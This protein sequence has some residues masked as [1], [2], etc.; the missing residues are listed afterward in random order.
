MFYLQSIKGFIS[1]M[2]IRTK[3]QVL[4]VGTSAV[5][6]VLAAMALITSEINNFRQEL[7]A[8]LNATAN[9]VGQNVYPSLI[10]NYA[11]SAGEILSSLSANE[12]ITKA[13]IVSSDRKIFA[14][15]HRDD[16]RQDSPENVLSLD[17][18]YLFTSNSIEVVQ[19]IT[20]DGQV[21]GFVLIASDLKKLNQRLLR[22]YQIAALV[23]VGAVGLAF[24]LAR[25]FQHFISAPI[26]QLSDTMQYVTRTKKYSIRAEKTTNDEVGGLIDG[27]NQMLEEMNK[28][29]AD[30]FKVNK[31]LEKVVS[32]LRIAK[33]AAEK[34]NLA[35]SQF[36]AK[37]SHEIRTPMNGVLGMVDLLLNSGLTNQQNRLAK[38]VRN[39]GVTL[40]EII[41]DILDFAKIE[42]DKIDLEI[43]EFNLVELV[44]SIC[45]LLGQSAYNKGIELG[46]Y[47]DARIPVIVKGDPLRMRQ[48]LINLMGNAV[49]FTSDGQVSLNVHLVE[50]HEGYVQARFEVIDSGVG[51]QEEA[52][53]RI[54]EAFSQANEETSRRFGGTGLGLSIAKQLVG[55]MGGDLAVKSKPNLGATFY[56]TINLPYVTKDNPMPRLPEPLRQVRPLIVDS[57]QISIRALTEKLKLMGLEPSYIDKGFMALEQ[58]RAMQARGT[59]YT[60]VFV[61]TNI[62]DM[63][64][65]KFIDAIQQDPHISGTHIVITAPVLQHTDIEQAVNTDFIKVLSKPVRYDV[66]LETINSAMQATH[67]PE[68]PMIKAQISLKTP[69]KPQRQLHIHDA[70]P[71]RDDSAVFR[72]LIAEDNPVNAEVSRGMLV[73][74]GY[75]VDIVDNG[76]KAVEAIKQHPYDLILM[77]GQ[78]P[79]MD[80]NEATIAI[81]VY[82]RETARQQNREADY[83]PIIAATANIV[84][85]VK[86][87]YI[88]AG[89][90]D[91]ITKPFSREQLEEIINKWIGKRDT[92][93]GLRAEFARTVRAKILNQSQHKADENSATQIQEDVALKSVDIA[94]LKRIVEIQPDGGKEF[95]NNIIEIYLKD[96]KISLNQMN[97][98]LHIGDSE[99]LRKIAHKLKSS[100]ANVGAVKLSKLAYAVE[101]KPKGDDIKQRVDAIHQE[102]NEVHSALSDIVTEGD[103]A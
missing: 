58:M 5:V 97:N 84:Q 74:Q 33:D 6:V 81:R 38:I 41:N 85:G 92:P 89:M 67:E 27:F 44:E 14:Q 43:V 18:G 1:Q 77:D 55:I 80:G 51:I 7:V 13:F 40:L 45:E 24:I 52:Q 29:T 42:A 90:N 91:F 25:T 94:A 31:N 56:F 37:M 70:L 46:G 3:L 47:I 23:L 26:L 72:V 86:D 96:T 19:S 8:E 93:P 99:A 65:F 20:L 87:E 17:D 39:S 78:M 35:K 98:A 4:V 12:N 69:E 60:L 79:V 100:S 73:A 61:S 15:Y 76:A 63:E 34:A 53:K 82:E 48:I 9:I 64:W 22:Y 16:V 10:F 95:L 21:I 71:V 66:L 88:A 36:L 11:G 54:F 59:P 68:Q 103:L 30:L 101:A 83:I 2:S 50:E 75:H 102:F 49:K 28:Q 57:A 32:E 62:T